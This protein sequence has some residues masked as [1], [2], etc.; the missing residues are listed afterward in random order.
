MLKVGFCTLLGVDHVSKNGSYTACNLKKFIKLL[1]MKGIWD[2]SRMWL[3]IV[4]FFT[5]SVYYYSF[6]C[7]N[8]VFSSCSGGGWQGG[9]GWGVEWRG[10]WRRG[11]NY[12]LKKK[13]HKTH[14]KRWIKDDK[15]LKRW[16]LNYVQ[17]VLAEGMLGA[18]LHFIR[19]K[20]VK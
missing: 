10:E 19:P 14:L 11:Q 13:P 8:F 9:V 7:I 4:A 6:I 17:K 12:W 3:L 20:N 1:Y 16:K 2:K 18:F 5:A 15:R